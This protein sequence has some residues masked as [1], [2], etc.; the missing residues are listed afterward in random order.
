MDIYRDDAVELDAVERYDKIL[1]SPGPGIPEEAGILMEV[2]QKY[3]PSKQILGVCL[4]HQAIGEVY[5]ATLYNL[6]EVLHG[7]PM[8]TTVLANE[9]PLFAG[10]P[11]DFNAARYH[12]WVI[13]KNSLPADLHLIASDDFGEIMGIRHQRHSVYGLQFHPESILTEHGI[14]IIQNWLAL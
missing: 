3:G 12:S 8:K 11:A 14:Q 7:I 1:L 10:L 9:D 13:E 5:G 4:G 2:I 6:P